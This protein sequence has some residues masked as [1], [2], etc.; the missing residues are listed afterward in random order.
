MSRALAR[1]ASYVEMINEFLKSLQRLT[2]ITGVILGCVFSARV[3]AINVADVATGGVTPSAMAS[4]LQGSGVTIS[5]LTI[6]SRG[7]CNSNAGVGL[8]TQGTIASGAGPVLGEP[9][10][11]IVA[12]SAFNNASNALNTPNNASNVTN[13]LCSGPTSDPDMVALEAGTVNGEYAAIEFDVIP[14]SNTLAIPFQFGSDEFPEYVCSNFGDVVGIFVSGAGINGPYSGSLNAENFAKTAGGDP[15]SINWVNTGIVGQSGNPASCGSLANAAFYTDNSNGSTTGGNSTVATTNANL[16]LDGYTNTLYQSIPVVAG[17][18][19]HVKIAVAD[20]A[21]RAYDSAAFIH[22]LFST[23]S[24][25]GFDYG[26]APDSYRTL[27]SNGGPGHGIDNTIFM[28]AATP[29]SEVTGIPGAGADGD[30]LSGNDD[31]DGVSVFPALLTT[32]TSYS[33]NVN[34]TN[35]TGKTA[36]LVG[37]IDFNQNGV[38]DAAEGS[39]VFV[40]NGINNGTASLTWSG[41]SGLTQGTTYVRI[42]FSSDLNLSTL[43]PGST[44]SDGEVEDYPLAIQSLNFDKYVSTNATCSDLLDAITVAP[45]TNVYFCYTVSNPN[46]QPFDIEAGNTSDDQG[47]DLSALE[48]SYAPSASQTV[49]IGPIIAGSTQ[50]PLGVTTINNAQVIA[51]IAG[52]S[53]ID[54]E[55]ASVDVINNP[56]ANGVKQLYFDTPGGT[57]NLTR[58]P[59]GSNSQ[60]GSTDVITLNQGIVFQ[61][62]FTITGG[63]TADVQLR[64]R[65]RSGGGNRTIQ[66]DL[67]NGNTGTLIGSTTTTLSGG[68]WKTL[69]APINIATDVNFAVGDFIRVVVRN[70]PASNGNIQLRTLQGAVRSE[71][72]VQSSTVINVDSIDVYAAASPATTKFLS[73]TPGS[74][75]YIRATV[76]DPFGNADI[77]AARISIT[78][79]AS[80][81]R[82]N[83][84]SMTS[85]ATP[86]GATRVYE[87]QYLVP[88]SP[89]GVWNI[90][91]TADEGTEGTV[92]HTLPANMV[93]GTAD[94]TISKNSMTL[95]DPIN[96]SKPKS[97]PNAVVEYT[98]TVSNSG[99]GYV[100]NNTIVLS[101]PISPATT[102]FF[103]SPLEPIV[104]VDGVNSSGLSFNFIDLASTVDDIDF[105]NDGGSNFITPQVDANGFDITSPRINFIRINPK[106]SFNG[107]DGSNHP[108]MEVKFKVRVD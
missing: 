46:T 64:I 21:D 108:S 59:P 14:Q 82:V 60:S 80:T 97:I 93:I 15:S 99:F 66:T 50:L 30:D 57:P 51:T 79:S 4:A 72:Q 83:N 86:D 105:S 6:T 8:F 38:F 10:G 75:V 77:S 92:S 52:S 3:A 33:V 78:D 107:S 103:G 24:F 74:T 35:T 49:I 13:S 2:L 76:S 37:W 40:A 54:N 5:N 58:S 20:S 87:Y 41:L 53:F 17:Q 104:F 45:A 73:Y 101:D 22:P 9:T 25:S 11:V 70:I 16:E 90:S 102:F 19:Y 96:A 71:L 27:T 26:D 55:S 7:G 18:T 12:N 29:D 91:V 62:P 69:Q 32:S 85:V 65:R 56:P 63:T 47:H 100:D 106:G 84:Q 36:R 39:S 34:V 1:S 81:L 95:T 98:I 61:A 28:G 68:G 88:A 44:M 67:Y 42:R 43:S 31:D 48:T 89:D 23:S 94:I